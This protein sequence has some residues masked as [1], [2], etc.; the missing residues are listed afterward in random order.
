MANPRPGATA[1]GSRRKAGVRPECSAA[2][3]A[4]NLLRQGKSPGMPKEQ[5][6]KVL[7]KCRG[8]NKPQAPPRA[9][10]EERL[11]RVQG[12]IQ[13]IR[14]RYKENP[15][16]PRAKAAYNR[17]I[18]RD[19]MATKAAEGG[20]LLA[21]LRARRLE[22]ERQGL[23]PKEQAAKARGE[24]GTREQRLARL[25][26]RAQKAHEALK[27]K[28]VEG[29]R[30]T[31]A[32]DRAIAIKRKIGQEEQAKGAAR[33]KALAEKVRT[34]RGATPKVAP[35]TPK[36]SPSTPKPVAAA[37]SKPA[38]GGVMQ[39]VAEA[40]A[41]ATGDRSKTAARLKAVKSER[42]RLKAEQ[43]P[44]NTDVPPDTI[45]KLNTDLIDADPERFQYKQLLTDNATGEVGSLA[46]VKKWNPKLAGIMAVWKDPDDGKVYV[47]NGHNRLAM[48][49]KLG[50]KD[51]AVQFLDSKNAA[52]ARAHGA[53]I[54]IAEGRGDA[55]DAAKFFRGDGNPESR[56]TLKDL[57]DRGIPLSEAKATEGLALAGLSDPIFHR[58]AV[59]RD[60][61]VKK[62]AIIGGAGLTPEQQASLVKSLDADP[63]MT[64]RELGEKAERTKFFGV[65]KKDTGP[66]L[67]GDDGG[68]EEA[69]GDYADKL[70]AHVGGEFSRRGSLFGT[71]AREKAAAT[72][73]AAGNVIDTEESAKLSAD[74]RNN[75]DAFK[76]WKYTSTIVPI[77]NEYAAKLAQAKGKGEQARI[78]QEYTDAV[79]ARIKK[80]LE[81]PFG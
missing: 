80:Q 1:P 53:L 29:D 74:A 14:D 19:A 64:S 3:T 55:I 12:K 30:Y 75:L 6:F 34:A 46:G 81:N 7:A 61:P 8:G 78:R 58:V 38:A 33:A 59:K 18:G 70:N 47:V 63:G 26:A 23:G 16:D 50:V 52:E 57:E 24:K 35:E 27:G 49:K 17:N 73:K 31:S 40:R 66:R 76:S 28:G 2:A 20:S 48:A 10:K 37:T 60:I 42:D 36:D 77:T 5:V 9:S 13:R 39:K 25:A 54:N 43:D 71:V 69:L 41:V 21:K 67:F 65:H 11:A 15:A 79:I 68:D 44:S 32:L 22:R 72:L 62:A 56:I 4:W 45:K 51:V